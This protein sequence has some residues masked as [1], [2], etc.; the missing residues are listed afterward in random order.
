M[1]QANPIH[2]EGFNTGV[3][4]GG[5]LS[6]YSQYSHEHF[7]SFV[8]EKDIQKIA[9]WGMDHVRLPVDYQVLED[10][11]NPL[12][13]KASGFDYIEQCIEWCRKAG[14]NLILDLHHAPGFSFT[15]L[16][17]NTL[18]SDGTMQDRFISLWRAITR[19]LSGYRDNIILELLNEIV[20]PN[21]A[22]WNDL[23]ARTVTAI[24]ELDPQRV[25]MIGGNHYN[26]ASHM[27]HIEVL[28]DVN[29]VY[30]F[31][32]YEPML[33]THQKAQW[34]PYLK[35]YDTAVEYPG[36][37]EDFDEFIDKNPQYK[38]ENG[39]MVGKYF[40]Q[41]HLRAAI[42]PAVEFK[43]R[44]GRWVYCGEYG[45][46]DESPLQ[47]RVRWHTDMV[48]ILK[49]H[50]FGRG[51]WSYKQ[52]NFGLVDEQSKVISDELVKVVSS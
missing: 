50:G 24:R 43:R 37:G 45:A 46:I 10:D 41:D 12:Q 15:S 16:D 39:W 20:L 28:D 19:Q 52:M 30:T 40:D 25:I 21:S 31:H 34:V 42:Q 26:S 35:E 29:I 4:L 22:P 14:L 23:S 5:W 18:F 1:S 33:F 8:Q 51:V 17:R 38:A 32:S 36:K 9:G 2:P 49:E 6:Q 3:N 27:E 44:T 48:G 11:E 7:K 13:Y 47:S